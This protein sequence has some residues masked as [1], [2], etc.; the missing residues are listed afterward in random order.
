MAKVIYRGHEISVER[1]KSMAGYGL[2]YYSIS[3]Q[4]D[5]FE[6]LSDYQDSTEK[7]R[8]MIAYLKIRVDDELES[9]DPWDEKSKDFVFR[10]HWS[11]D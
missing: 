8:D 5:G 7:I 2:L 9:L 3:R 1:Q 11:A 6:C 4:S 10:S